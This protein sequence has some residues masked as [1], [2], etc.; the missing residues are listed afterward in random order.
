MYHNEA[1]VTEVN[2]EKK[3]KTIFIIY[4]T[5]IENEWEECSK[6]SRKI[7]NAFDGK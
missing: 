5:C 1:A 3:E 4:I 6:I 2:I 7:I